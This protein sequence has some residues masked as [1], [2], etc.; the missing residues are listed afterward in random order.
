MEKVDKQNQHKSRREDKGAIRW[1][2][3]TT[4]TGGDAAAGFSASPLFS[5]GGVAEVAALFSGF[6]PTVG[7]F[8]E[9]S[10]K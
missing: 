3:I 2:N 8:L 9:L 4:L 10:W 1:E 5:A 6:L 7:S